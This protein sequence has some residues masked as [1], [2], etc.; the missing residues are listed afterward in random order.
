MQI[1]VLNRKGK[2]CASIDCKNL[3]KFRISFDKV[4][5]AVCGECA[6]LLH[7]LLSKH[8]VPHSIKNKFNLD[9]GG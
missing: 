6:N 4:S 2:C 7:R 8:I 9:Q 3:A 1:E 5:V